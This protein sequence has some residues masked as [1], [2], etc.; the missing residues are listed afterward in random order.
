MSTVLFSSCIDLLAKAAD[1][2]QQLA[3]LRA[4]LGSAADDVV[5]EQ[6]NRGIVALEQVT[7]CQDRIQTAITILKSDEP[8]KESLDEV[9]SLLFELSCAYLDGM[10]ASRDECIVHSIFGIPR[11]TMAGDL[12][13]LAGDL[14]S[15]LYPEAYDF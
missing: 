3:Q 8:S 11:G 12:Y 14:D 7:E 1:A 13:N 2:P 4:A 15:M 6:V 9:K 10:C 5:R